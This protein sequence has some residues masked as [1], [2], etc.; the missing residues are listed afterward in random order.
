[1]NSTVSLFLQV[2]PLAIG[3]AFSPTFLAMQVVVLTS[4]APGAVRRGWAL[5]AGSM[6]ALLLVSFGGLSLLASLSDFQTGQPSYPQAIIFTLAGAAL[7][8]VALVLSRRPPER[9]Q[10]KVLNRVG[11]AQP[12]LLFAI[13]ALRLLVNATTLA[14][15]IPALHVITHS[16]VE[17]AAKAAV[18]VMLFAIT[19]IAVVGPVLAVT[20]LGDRAKPV[21]TGI[22]TSLDKHSRALT[23]WTC[24]GFGVV[25]VAAGVRVFIQVA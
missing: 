25:L 2:L 24:L 21:L 9:R 8:L 13:G 23:I 18:F 20:L 3:A 5:A 6:V 15:Y 14:L 7:L 11:D 22:H 19:E 1:M 16:T 12:P 17:A 4:P 10:S